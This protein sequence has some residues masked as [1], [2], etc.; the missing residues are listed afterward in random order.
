ML[1]T[2]LIGEHCNRATAWLTRF[3]VYCSHRYLRHYELCRRGNLT[4]TEIQTAA[5]DILVCVQEGFFL[6]EMISLRNRNPVRKNSHIASLNPVLVD[7]LVRSKGRLIS[8][9]MN[10]CPII[11][12]S[13]HHVTTLIIRHLHE[14]KGHIGIQQALAATCEN[15]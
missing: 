3:K 8:G 7:G 12:P 1:I 15:Y 5:D 13:G 14:T 10:K 2:T 4:L 11:L 9:T 6:N